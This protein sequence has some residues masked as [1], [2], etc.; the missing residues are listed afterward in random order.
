MVSSEFPEPVR[1]NIRDS[2]SNKAELAEAA[3]VGPA[4][5]KRYGLVELVNAG[6]SC[7]CGEVKERPAAYG[8]ASDS[9]A[10]SS[11][12][13]PPQGYTR[14]IVTIVH[15]R[16]ASVFYYDSVSGPRHRAPRLE[17]LP[18][19]LIIKDVLVFFDNATTKS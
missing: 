8:R 4:T 3:I 17:G 14:F 9:H 11:E 5:S 19:L 7:C 12:A 6:D 15:C 16:S 18:R 13:D 10:T 2:E 1:M